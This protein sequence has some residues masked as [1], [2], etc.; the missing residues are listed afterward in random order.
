MQNVR[1]VAPEQLV[2]GGVQRN[3]MT[4]RLVQT[5]ALHTWGPDAV[6][7]VSHVGQRHETVL[8]AL[9]RQTVDQLDDDVLQPPHVEAVHEMHQANGRSCTHAQTTLTAC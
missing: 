5:D 2:D 3:G 4:W 7:K 1:A 6:R 9:R 8:V